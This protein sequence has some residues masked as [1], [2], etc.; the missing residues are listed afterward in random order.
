MF[1]A[2]YPC[3]YIHRKYIYGREQ[4]LQHLFFIT[5]GVLLGFWNYGNQM[6]HCIST[7]I[8]TYII[9]LTVGG[10]IISVAI[11]FVFSLGYLLVGKVIFSNEK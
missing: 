9:I 8:F 3:A 7:I 4:N 6:F 1:F 10:T 11:I 2:G 5:A